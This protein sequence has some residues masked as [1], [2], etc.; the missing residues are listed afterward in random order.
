MCAWPELC[1]YLEVTRHHLMKKTGVH[2]SLCKSQVSWPFFFLLLQTNQWKP[3]SL[4]LLKTGTLFIQ[5]WPTVE[6]YF[7]C[8][9]CNEL[10]RQSLFSRC[11]AIFF[12]EIMC[13]RSVNQAQ[14]YYIALSHVIICGMMRPCYLLGGE[15]HHKFNHCQVLLIHAKVPGV[16]FNRT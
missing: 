13:R 9:A 5:P 6:F 7:L 16:I 11:K 15:E 10:H 14:S 3:F 8:V 4:L 2:K 1:T 12:S